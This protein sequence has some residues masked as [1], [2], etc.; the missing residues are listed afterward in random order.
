VAMFAALKDQPRGLA[1][2]QRQFSRDFAVRAPAN[3]I[4][5][6]MLAPHRKILLAISIRLSRLNTAFCLAASS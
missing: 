2:L 4:G 1:H 3:A 5:A 6:E